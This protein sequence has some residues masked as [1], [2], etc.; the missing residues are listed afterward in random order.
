[1]EKKLIF[2]HQNEKS[3]QKLALQLILKH[4]GSFI[5]LLFSRD[6]EAGES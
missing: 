4:G 1:M 3:G 2:F 5:M 6:G